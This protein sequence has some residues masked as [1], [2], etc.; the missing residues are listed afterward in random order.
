MQKLRHNIFAM[1][2][3]AA[4]FCAVAGTAHAVVAPGL[5]KVSSAVNVRGADPPAGRVTFVVP[6]LN[7]AGE[8]YPYSKTLDVRLCS[9]V[10]T[11]DCQVRVGITT[12]MEVQC[13][14]GM[15]TL[16]IYASDEG[17]ADDREAISLY[18]G[19]D[20]P[21]K[22]RNLVCIPSPD[23]ASAEL[24]WEAPQIGA[25]A[26]TF[27]A[28]SLRYDIYVRENGFEPWRL[29]AEG[30]GEPR[31]IY[32][33]NP[34]A[35]Q[36]PVEI[37]VHAV[38][39]MG[40]SGEYVRAKAYLGQPLIL[41]YVETFCGEN[42]YDAIP[43]LQDLDNEELVEWRSGWLSE[44]MPEVGGHGLYAVDAN[45]DNVSR[46]FRIAIPRFS[47]GGIMQASISMRALFGDGAAVLKLFGHRHDEE[48]VTEI[49]RLKGK[50]GMEEVNVVL[51]VEY[52]GQ[53]WV[54][55]SIEAE[56]SGTR[57]LAAIADV[58]VK[59]TFVGIGEIFESLSSDDADEPLEIYSL[60]GCLLTRCRAAE[61]RSLNLRPGVYI[62]RQGERV[63]KIR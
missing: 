12:A 10:D 37:G 43:W 2:S 5:I 47:T 13:L 8:V 38:N 39:E 63:W 7:A 25:H 53:R 3:A 54:E 24:T 59:E 36:A 49:C 55:L 58:R 32:K 9:E 11:V 15:N 61:L 19:R 52:S 17:L 28:D 20:I 21:A 23:M 14:Q 62:M 26:A 51:P 56:F 1:A 57:K 29:H 31:Y 45:L 16:E 35:E 41:P 48:S 6:Q 4:V 27:T 18:A 34:D 33:V 44:V 46:K 42:G 50:E 60:D 22:V 40:G 30:V